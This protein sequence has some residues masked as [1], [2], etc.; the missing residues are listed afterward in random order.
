MRSTTRILF[1]VAL[2][3]LGNV[4]SVRPAAARDTELHLGIADVLAEY[5]DQL[6]TD[7]AFYFGGQPSP[8]VTQ[9]FDAYVT[10]RKT[11]SVGPMMSRAAGRCSRP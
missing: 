9:K 7:V 2:L 11:N 3:V 10:N 1:L 4:V 8:A 5:K 6:G